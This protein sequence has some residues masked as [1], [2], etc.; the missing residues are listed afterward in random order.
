MGELLGIGKG[1][2]QEQVLTCDSQSP[3]AASRSR[4]QLSAP[5]PASSATLVLP[6]LNVCQAGGGE[7]VYHGYD[8]M[9][10]PNF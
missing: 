7:C 10:F 1:Q 2:R 8:D 4:Q 6:G 5:L 3:R 9:H